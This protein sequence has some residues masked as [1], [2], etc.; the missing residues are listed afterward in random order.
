MNTTPYNRTK[1]DWDSIDTDSKIIHLDEIVDTIEEVM[2]NKGILY[3]DTTVSALPDDSYCAGLIK[4]SRN[5]MNSLG[6]EKVQI[7]TN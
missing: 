5:I 3:M 6:I 1:P 2:G 4:E 7:P